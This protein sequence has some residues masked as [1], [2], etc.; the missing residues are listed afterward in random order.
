MKNMKQKYLFIL[1]GLIAAL[2]LTSCHTTRK[3]T[4]SLTGANPEQARFEAVVN[5][6][7]KYESLVSKVKLSMGKT[8]LNGKMCLE[9]GKR[10]ALLANAPL[11]GFEIGRIEAT[12]ESVILVDK[13][14]KLYSEVSLSE[15]TQIDALS[16]H[17]MEAVE[18][19][20]FGRIFIPGVGQAAAKDYS[21]LAWS[22]LKNADG[23]QGN[24]VGVFEGKDYRLVY[25]INS[26]GQLVS[27]LLAMSDG[28]EATWKYSNYTEVE[29]QKTV[30][31]NEE[32]NA[33]YG[34]SKSLKAGLTMINP[35]LEE[36]SWKVFTPSSSFR[37]VTVK[38]LGEVLKQHM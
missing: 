6:S 21:R 34:G 12:P 3:T 7:Y 27:T 23:T 2:A 13:F 24:S 1:V 10:F 38:E 37:K 32:I 28:K 25:E 35:A 18:C 29:K 5:N 11:L 9:S 30:P 20:M 17:E 19:L 33:V 15:L 31:A 14:D 4:G 22:T 36:S 16:G 8:S 26:A